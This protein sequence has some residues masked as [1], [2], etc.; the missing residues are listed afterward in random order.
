MKFFCIT[1]NGSDNLELTKVKKCLENNISVLVFAFGI[2][3]CKQY[4]ISAHMLLKIQ[5]C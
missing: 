5:C 4:L 2:Y 3:V 1:L